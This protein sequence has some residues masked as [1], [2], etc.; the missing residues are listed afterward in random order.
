MEFARNSI[1]TALA[2]LTTGLFSGYFL[3]K[4]NRSKDLP[5]SYLYAPG[6]FGSPIMIGRYCS[7]YHSETGEIILGTR[8]GDIFGNGETI[9]TVVFPEINIE[10]PQGWFRTKITPAIAQKMFS[11]RF[12]IVVKNFRLEGKTFFNYSFYPERINIGQAEDIA[13]LRTA[14]MNHCKQYP[15][16]KTILFGD[17]RGAAT[18]FCFLALDHPSVAGAILEGIFDSIPH[19]TTHCFRWSWKGTGIANMFNKL[20]G[21]CAGDF[22][23]DG[24]FP[25]DYVDSFPY[26]TPVLLVTSVNDEIVPFECTVRLYRMLKARNHKNVRLLMLK[27][28]SHDSYMLKSEKTMYEECVHAFY[29]ACGAAHDAEKAERGAQYLERTNPTDA[30]ILTFKKINMDCCTKDLPIVPA[31]S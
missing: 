9:S 2:L 20:V 21:A 23:A 31:K 27:H 8:G 26:D 5:T 22:K 18:T 4:K 28:A 29:K 14:Y 15:N 25:I 16:H 24:P 11:D 17:S 6:L 30:E 10:A 1:L 19:I 13:A 3:T 12:G 7:R